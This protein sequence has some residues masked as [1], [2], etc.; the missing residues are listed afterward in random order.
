V[1][2]VKNVSCVTAKGTKSNCNLSQN[3]CKGK[4]QGLERIN[5]MEIESLGNCGNRGNNRYVSGKVEPG[6]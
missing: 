6:T 3:M 2:S 1:D 4:I 5:M